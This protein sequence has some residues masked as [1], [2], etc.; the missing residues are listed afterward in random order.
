MCAPW[1]QR[2]TEMIENDLRDYPI[3]FWD[4]INILMD[5]LTNVLDGL[6]QLATIMQ[7]TVSAD[8]IVVSF[9]RPVNEALYSLR[10][11]L[12][13]LQWTF[14]N[15]T[16]IDTFN[17][18][19]LRDVLTVLQFCCAVWQREAAVHRDILQ[20]NLREKVESTQQ[21]CHFALLSLGQQH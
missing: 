17:E 8:I 3:A 20:S 6:V 4:L 16:N 10:Y 12:E 1:F 18:N 9:L 21:L 7:N 11:N 19:V 13:Y 2:A 14:D 15:V 5:N